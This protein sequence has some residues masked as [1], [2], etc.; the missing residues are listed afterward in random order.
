ME[1]HQNPILIREYIG[2]TKKHPE[3]DQISSGNTSKPNTRLGIHRRR[4]EINSRNTSKRQQICGNASENKKRNIMEIHQNGKTYSEMHR[5]K[6]NGFGNTSE[7][8]T[9]LEIHRRKRNKF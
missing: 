2:E 1:L 8:H 7:H 4:K 9:H 6:E 5:T 3:I